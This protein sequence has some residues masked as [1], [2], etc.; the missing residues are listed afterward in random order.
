MRLTANFNDK[1]FLREMNNLMDYS[2]GFLNGAVTG[3]RAFLENLG[4]STIEA[5]KQFIDSMARVEPAALHHVY[6]WSMT[7]SPDARLFDIDYTVSNLGL[8]IKSTFRQSTSIK[9]GSTVPFYNKAKIMEE[10]S[11]VTIRPKKSNFLVFTN[12]EGEEV[13]VQKPV[14]VENPGG[15][16]VAGRYEQT[17]DTFILNYFSQSFLNA[18]GILDKLKDLSVYKRNISSGSKMGASRGREIGYRWIVNAG[19]IR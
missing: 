5:L 16:Q 15:S 1:D 19:V 13:F 11:P 7:G 17:F 6:E 8:S 18:S 10:G 12:E 3:K 2:F 14:V 9:A 4:V